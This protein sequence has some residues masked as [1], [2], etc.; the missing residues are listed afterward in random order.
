MAPKAFLHGQHDFALL[1][2][3]FSKNSI[4]HSCALWLITCSDVQLMSLRQSEGS[5]W[6]KIK[7]VVCLTVMDKGFVQSP[8]KF[9]PPPLSLSMDLW[10]KSN[11]FRKYVIWCARLKFLSF[12]DTWTCFS[13]CPVS[14]LRENLAS[15]MY[16]ISQMDSDQYVPI[17]TVANLD[18]VKKLSTDVELIVDIL[19]CEWLCR[20]ICCVLQILW[21]TFFCVLFWS[22]QHSSKWCYNSSYY[23]AFT[24]TKAFYIFI[25]Q[26]FD[27]DLVVETSCVL[28]GSLYLTPPPVICVIIL[29]PQQNLGVYQDFFGMVRL[30]ENT[31]RHCECLSA[32]TLPISLGSLFKSLRLTYIIV[33]EL[34][35]RFIHSLKLMLSSLKLNFKACSVLQCPEF[36]YFY[37]FIL[38]S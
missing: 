21:D 29:F 38:F 23:F 32:C 10:D 15:D 33:F 8:S 6:L 12:S 28:G 13:N 22:A 26:I 3:G 11:R 2:T 5:S 1:L 35:T 18:H 34:Y 4:K 24:A 31:G 25:C 27:K 16:L 36:T 7:W 9:C 19:R 37:V 30:C 17:V 14:L 20:A